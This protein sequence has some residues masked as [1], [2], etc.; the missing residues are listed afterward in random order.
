MFFLKLIDFNNF[1]L[2]IL[3]NYIINMDNLKVMIEIYLFWV[4]II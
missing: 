1:I 3:I 2:M 4:G